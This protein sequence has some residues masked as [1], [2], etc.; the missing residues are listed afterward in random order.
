[1]PRISQKGIYIPASPIRKL[2]PY[3]EQAIQ[4]GL[5]VLHLNI[6]NP[7]IATPQCAL[8]AIRNIQDTVL[9]Y[10]HTAG[11]LPFRQ[12]LVEYYHRAGIELTTG[13]VL[14]TVGGSEALFMAM[15]IC[16]DAGEEILVPEPF[17]ANYNGFAAEAGVVIRP[18]RSVIDNDFALPSIEDFERLM[19]PRTRAILICNPNN[20]TG[21]LYSQK[22]LDQLAEI[23]KRKDL[24]LISDEVYREFCYDGHKHISTMNLKGIEQNVIMVDSFSKRYSMCG[25]RLGVFASHNKEVIAAATKMAQARLC[26]PY[27]AQVAA[28]AAI[29][30]PDEYFQE[31]H[32]E[33]SRRRDCIID[34]LNAIPNVHCPRPKG[35]F[36]TVA[37]LPIDDCDKFAQWLLEEFSFNGKT[38]MLAP[39]TGFYASPEL[40]RDEVRIAYVIN[41]EDLLAAA[42]CIKEAL[43]VY[44]GRTK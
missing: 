24:Y 32:D 26:P 30:A 7:D 19:S 25:I 2:V 11:T 3:A 29:D 33:Y 12:K 1:M 17:Y 28:V 43:K 41:C 38:V 23:V 4:R 36:Y 37:K 31:V 34:A 40:G 15:S 5:K 18:V 20:P 22:E 35:A 42:E 16:A 6:G 27:L 9:G 44:P 14:G 10:T 8:D 21:Y 39:G 13:E